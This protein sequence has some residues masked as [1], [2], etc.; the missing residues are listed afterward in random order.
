MECSNIVAENGGRHYAENLNQE[1]NHYCHNQKKED[2]VQLDSLLAP[3]TRRPKKST[4][5]FQPPQETDNG[6]KV[7]DDRDLWMWICRLRHD[8]DDN[9]VAITDDR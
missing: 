5:S 6:V 2:M 3:M 8:I 9:P 7:L 4:P 1:M